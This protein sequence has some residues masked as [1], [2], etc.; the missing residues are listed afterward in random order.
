M[1]RL[2]IALVEMPK[3]TLRVGRV[4]AGEALAEGS[5]ASDFRVRELAVL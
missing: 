4:R 2:C 3:D 5:N 1:R